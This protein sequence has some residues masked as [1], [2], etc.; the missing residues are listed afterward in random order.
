[1]YVSYKN[2]MNYSQISRSS[3]VQRQK[4]I[5]NE[6][7]QWLTICYWTEC[8][9]YILRHHIWRWLIY[10][11]IMFGLVKGWYPL[12]QM[13]SEFGEIFVKSGQTISHIIYNVSSYTSIIWIIPPIHSKFK[14]EHW[15]LWLIWVVIS[16]IITRQDKLC[17]S[18][19]SMIESI[20]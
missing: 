15:Y 9:V 16:A 20:W 12:V 7:I 18:L 10:W 19:K 4:P 13:S 11:L 2:Y 3:Q 14:Y 1:M 5:K 17:G 6:S 8:R